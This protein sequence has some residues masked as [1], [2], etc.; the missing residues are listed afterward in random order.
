MSFILCVCPGLIA[1]ESQI[2]IL[3]YLLHS[4]ILSMNISLLTTSLTCRPVSLSFGIAKIEFFHY[5]H[6]MKHTF[7]NFFLKKSYLIVFQYITWILS[8]KKW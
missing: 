6:P 5:T 8:G 4:F 3:E 1:C 2:P 7:L